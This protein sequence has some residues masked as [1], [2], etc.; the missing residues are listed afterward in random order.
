MSVCAMKKRLGSM[1]AY[2]RVWC[3]DSVCDSIPKEVTLELVL[4]GYWKLLGEGSQGKS[5]LGGGR[6]CSKVL[7]CEGYVTG[8][9]VWLEGRGGG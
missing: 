7:S 9:P 2:G 5:V 1:R 4:K 6:T 3:S 8:R